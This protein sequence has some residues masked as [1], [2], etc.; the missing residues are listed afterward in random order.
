MVFK[1]PHHNNVSLAILCLFLF[2][3]AFIV[4]FL[5]KQPA[6]AA[7]TQITFSGI[8]VSGNKLVNQQGQQVVLHGVDRSGAEFDCVGGSVF[9]GPSDAS[10]IQ[11][12]RAWGI[13]VVRVPLNEDCWL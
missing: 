9:D 12:M 1:N 7:T 10:S 13:D 4:I 6:Y 8:K 3:T 2:I 5:Q 11:A